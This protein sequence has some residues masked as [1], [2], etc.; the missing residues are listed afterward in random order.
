MRETDSMLFPSLFL[1][2]LILCISILRLCILFAC[3]LMMRSRFPFCCRRS[4]C[5]FTPQDVV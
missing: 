2:L 5:R 1:L 4:V 3:L